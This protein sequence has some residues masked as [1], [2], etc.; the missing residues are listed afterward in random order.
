MQVMYAFAAINIVAIIVLWISSTAN[1]WRVRPSEYTST[2]GDV[3]I[4]EIAVTY[5]F[6]FKT[7]QYR[8][9]GEY[10]RY[11]SDRSY[12]AESGRKLSLSSRQYDALIKRVREIAKDEVATKRAWTL[13]STEEKVA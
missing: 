9:N 12:Y 2:N 7:V 3:D 1:I 5:I 8:T 10:D 13:N 11:T 4:T 6:P